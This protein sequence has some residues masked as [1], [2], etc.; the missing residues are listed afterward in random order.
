MIAY[1]RPQ[2][3]YLESAYAHQV[4]LWQEASSFRAY[5]DRHL[6]RP[7]LEYPARLGQWHQ[8]FGDRLSLHPYDLNRFPGGDVSRHFWQAVDRLPDHPDRAVKSHNLR[9]GRRTVEML[10]LLRQTLVDQGL[11]V[12]T[13]LDPVAAQARRT[14]QD[15]LPD[16]PPFRA[17]TPELLMR[18]HTRFEESNRRFI[19]QHGEQHAH[20]LEPPDIDDPPRP[21]TIEDASEGER[22]L[23][24]G[25]VDQAIVGLEAGGA[26][27]PTSP[28]APAGSPMPPFAYRPPR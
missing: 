14:V 26:S 6:E 16:D 21:W 25:L 5:V 18:I 10:S 23:F 12:V 22:Q 2:W 4:T 24:F 27:R 17:L 9:P 1:V 11:E 19:E 8:V 15:A 3:E 28:S 20:L 7:I 13:P